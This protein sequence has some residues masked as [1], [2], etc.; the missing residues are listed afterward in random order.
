MMTRFPKIHERKTRK[1]NGSHRL[2]IDFRVLVEISR[3][4]SA[5]QRSQV[6]GKQTPVVELE[7]PENSSTWQIKGVAMSAEK[8]H[9]P[10]VMLIFGSSSSRPRNDPIMKAAASNHRAL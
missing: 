4:R 10:V 9:H 7:S 6:P 1:R 3:H 8:C 5:V 2:N